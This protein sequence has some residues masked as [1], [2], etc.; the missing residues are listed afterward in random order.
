M[1]VATELF[2]D[3][4][5][6]TLL[7]LYPDADRW[8]Q[9]FYLLSDALSE[10]D[11]TLGDFARWLCRI[12]QRPTNQG[13]FSGLYRWWWAGD[14]ANAD[15]DVARYKW[16]RDKWARDWDEYNN[17][18]TRDFDRVAA[19]DYRRT[20]YDKPKYLNTFADPLEPL[21]LAFG[22]W[23]ALPE[24]RRNELWELARRHKPADAPL[25]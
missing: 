21:E 11:E 5:R 9:Y 25:L 10:R 22:V 1:P 20:K 17:Y 19:K 13:C 4:E 14:V 16:A 12:R 18:L 7:A 15:R 2:T 3:L 6:Q 24:A 8:W 23:A